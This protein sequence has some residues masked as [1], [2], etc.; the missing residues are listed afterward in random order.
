MKNQK[1][2]Y[3]STILLVALISYTSF[4]QYNISKY[5]FGTA[6]QK[7]TSI[8]YNMNGT[9]SQ[10]AIGISEGTNYKLYSGFWYTQSYIIT[11]IT[12]VNGNVSPTSATVTHGGTPSFIITPDAG[13]AFGTIAVDGISVIGN[14]HLLG[15]NTVYTFPPVTSSHTFTA[16]FIVENDGIDPLV[17]DG[18]PNNG[19]ANNDGM[20]D[21]YQANVTSLPSATNNGYITVELLTGSIIHNVF[22]QSV[23]E[24]QDKYTYQYPFGLVGFEIPSSSANVKLYF[25]GIVEF[26]GY[27]YRKYGPLPPSYVGSEWYYFDNCTFSSENIGGN[28]VGTIVL[29]FTDGRIGDDTGVDG[30]IF[31]QGGP[32]IPPIPTMSEWALIIMG[33]LFIVIGVW[34]IY[35]RKLI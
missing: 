20:L 27:H 4:C 3:Y 25:H 8:N 10:T 30:I 14:V 26:S 23:D 29:H 13:Y 5:T 15:G 32:V 22:T 18:G 17:E 2:I 19:D 6:G 34:Y 21:K 35:K 11:V 12:G 28:F 1:K 24:Y 7:T 33:L 16:T 9:V 31:D